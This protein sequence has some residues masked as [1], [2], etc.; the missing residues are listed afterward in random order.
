MDERTFRIFVVDD[1]PVARMIVLD[2]LRTKG[3]ELVE[4]A[5]GAACLAAL[6]QQPDLILMD[7]EMPRLDGITVC[8]QIREAGDTH[9][10][11]IFIS[12]HD[13]IEIRLSAYNAGGTD[14][15]AKPYAPVELEAKIVLAQKLSRE[16]H[17]LAEQASYA[18]KAAFTA[19]SSMGETGVVLNFLRASFGC[20]R[21]ADVAAEVLN[22]VQQFGLHGAVSINSEIADGCY[23]LGG[24]CTPL[25][26]S[27]LDKARSFERIFQFR[28][29]MAVNYPR[30]TLI[31]SRIPLDD[32][33]RAGRLRDHLALIIE[34][35]DARMQALENEHRR[36]AQAE[37][38]LVAVGTLTDAL[39]AIQRQ[40][41]HNNDRFVEVA[42]G[43]MQAIEAAFMNLGLTDVQEEHLLKLAQHSL[44]EM[45]AL[46]NAGDTLALNLQVA[47]QNLKALVAGAA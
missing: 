17:G 30:V 36:M 24:A 11:V 14:F 16:K 20:T 38:V 3:Y 25:E 6:A 33:E 27:I 13:D 47:I 32:E 4:F 39:T 7:V 9:A 29:R 8:R 26:A 10:Q 42:S 19:L 40:Q 35:A 2:Q 44:E 31:I 5:D 37:G 12:A 22:S 43:Y 45:T 15:I 23:A 21:Q 41:S 1:D 46:Q 28:D 18:Q 34:G